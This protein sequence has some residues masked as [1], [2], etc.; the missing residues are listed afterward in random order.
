MGWVYR[1]T[2]MQVEDG[3]INGGGGGSDGDGDGRS[4]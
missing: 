2:G 3:E 4:G 1:W